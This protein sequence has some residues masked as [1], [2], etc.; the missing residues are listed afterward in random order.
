M[1]SKNTISQAVILCAG[2]GTRIYP[3]TLTKPKPLLKVCGKTILG[4]NLDQ[5]QGLVKEAILV[6]GYKGEQIKESFGDRY[7]NISI[8]YVWQKQALGTGDAAKKASS[9]IKDRFLLLYGDDLHDK[10]DIKKCI[11]KFP[12]ILLKRVQEPSAFGQVKTERNNVKYLVEKPKTNVSNLVNTGVYYLDKSIFDFNIKKSPRGEYEFTDYIKHFI[13]TEKL[14]Y[15]IAE[16]WMPIPYVWSLLDANES[17]LN[18][19]KKKNSGICDKNSIIEGKV[20]IEEGS[21]IKNGVRIEGPAYIGKGCVIGPNA[22]IRKHSCIGEGCRIGQAV[23]IKNSIIGQGTFVPHLS[24]VGDSV[25]GD[26]CNFGA[27]TI[28]ANLRH[29]GANVNTTVKGKLIDTR[30]RKFGTVFGDN[31]KAGIGTLVYP[32]RK[33]WPDKL[34]KPGEIVKKDII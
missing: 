11:E 20:I 29:D 23:E 31:V 19:A 22:F 28:V 34:T 24:Y 18:K 12:C 8:K 3:L 32:G 15:G 10:Q 14:N 27:R 17:L 21:V 30:R 6:I 1:K 33:I 2:R 4:H 5:L 26:N 16:N 13:K 25:I 9:L 7:K